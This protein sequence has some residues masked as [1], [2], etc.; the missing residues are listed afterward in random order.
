MLT[1]ELISVNTSLN[2]WKMTL[3]IYNMNRRFSPFISCFNKRTF[4]IEI[5]NKGKI[6]IFTCRKKIL[7]DFN[8]EQ[9]LSFSFLYNVKGYLCFSS[10]ASILTPFAI[11]YWPID[12]EDECYLYAINT[13]WK[14]T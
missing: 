14:R 11:R 13:A 2:N 9:F 7:T 4:L 1:Q 12:N 10:F 3:K 5:S 6:T 8:I